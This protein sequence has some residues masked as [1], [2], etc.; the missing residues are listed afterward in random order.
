MKT[1]WLLGKHDFPYEVDLEKSSTMVEKGK[2]WR[3]TEE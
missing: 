3:F 1:Y 2:Y